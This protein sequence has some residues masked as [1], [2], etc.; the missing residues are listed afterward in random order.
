MVY[1]LLNYINSLDFAFQRNFLLFDQSFY[2]RRNAVMINFKP[3]DNP[4]QNKNDDMFT[5]LVV[6]IYTSFALLLF[7]QNVKILLWYRTNILI[8]ILL[9]L[10]SVHQFTANSILTNTKNHTYC[11]F[12]HRRIFDFFV[13]K[14]RFY[15]TKKILI[16][17]NFT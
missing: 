13:S 3:D 5:L 10:A 12:L 17:Y 1:N 7:P 16:A 15:P 11:T 9:L 8:A 6:E 2:Y 4:L 14:V